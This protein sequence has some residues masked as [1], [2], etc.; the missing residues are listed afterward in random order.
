MCFVLM[1]VSSFYVFPVNFAWHCS[2]WLCLLT[3]WLNGLYTVHCRIVFKILELWWSKPIVSRCGQSKWYACADG[4]K[5]ACCDSVEISCTSGNSRAVPKR[6]LE[7][8]THD[9]KGKVHAEHQKDWGGRGKGWEMVFRW[10]W[11]VMY[12]I[13]FLGP[14]QLSW[15]HSDLHQMFSNL[16]ST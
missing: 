16:K 11:P 8:P 7:N 6:L 5:C 2:S 9:I 13:P 12:P 14:H 3:N 15:I 4:C 10:L 1:V